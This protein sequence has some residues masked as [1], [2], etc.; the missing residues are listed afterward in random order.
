[1]M[2]KTRSPF[3][4]IKKSKL[5][6][7][8]A[9]ATKNIPKKTKVIEYVGE[10]IKR[11]EGDRREKLQELKAKNK[12]NAGVVYIFELNNNYDIDGSVV[13]N[14]AKYINHSCNPN[15]ETDIIKNHIWIIAIKNIKKGKELTYDYGYDIDDFEKHPCKCKSKNCVGFILD[16]KYWKR[17]KKP[18]RKKLDQNAKIDKLRI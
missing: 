18:V 7:K 5:H 10:K 11:K 4:V 16:K 9:F 14:T 17:I 3:L 1:M 2:Q 13:W 6:G 12:K 8:G 15:C